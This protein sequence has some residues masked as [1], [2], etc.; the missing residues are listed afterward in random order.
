MR[1]VAA[2]ALLG[3]TSCCNCGV[4]PPVVQISPPVLEEPKQAPSVKPP[5]AAVRQVEAS[6]SKAKESARDYVVSRGSE[7][8]KIDELG[9]LT[10]SLNTALAKMHANAV[11]GVYRPDD[12][13]QS[14]EAVY[15]LRVYLAQ[16]ARDD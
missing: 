12:I 2:I 1:I 11:K 13:R 7:P 4:L 5:D 8:E 16:T 6:A 9:V 14:N 3:V 10:L 15:K